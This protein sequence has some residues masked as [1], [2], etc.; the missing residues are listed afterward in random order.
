MSERSDSRSRTVNW[1]RAA[2]C[3]LALL[4]LAALLAPAFAAGSAGPIAPQ[5]PELVPFEQVGHWVSPAINLQQLLAEDRANRSRK[6]IPYRIG[7]PMTVDFTPANSGTWEDLRGGGRVWRFVVS[8]DAAIWVVLGFDVYDLPEGASLFVYDPAQKTV[9]GPYTVSDVREHHQLWTPP[10]EGDTLVV[11][12]NWPDKLKGSEPKL[13]LGTVSHGY[14]PF[15]TIGRAAW[16]AGAGATEAE[17][18][19][20]SCN[21]DTMCP[22]GANWQNEKRGVVILLS[23]GSGFCSASLINTTA[24]DCRPYVLTAHHCLAGASTVFGFNFEHTACGSGSPGLPTLHTVSGATVLADYAWSSTA[25]Q[26]SDFTLLQMSSQ[27][28]EAFNVYYNGWN[29]GTAA[30]TETHVIHHPSGDVKKISYDADPA[31]DGTLG[32]GSTGYGPSHWRIAHY[33]SGTTEG[34]SSG[35]PL[36]DQNHHI[37]GQ[38]HGGLASCTVIDWDEYGKVAVSWDGGGTSASRLSDWLDPNVTGDLTMDGVDYQ[39][40]AFNPAGVVTLARDILACTDTITITVRDDNLRGNPT[41]D[42]TITSNTETTPETVTLTAREPGSGFFDGTFPVA[43]IPAVHGDGTLSVSPGDTVTVLYIDADNGSGGVNVPVTATA[44]VDCVGPVITNVRS[45]NVTGNSAQV[46]WDTNETSN[47]RVTYD[48]VIPP[49]AG[50]ATSA[51]LGVSHQVN[52]TGLNPCS[53]YYYSVTST[54]AAG[55][56]TTDT[57]GGLYYTFKTGTNVSPTYTSTDTPIAIPDNNTTGATSTIHVP[58]FDYLSKL[59]VTVNV[60]H[61]YDGDLSLSLIAPDGTTVIPLSTRRGTSGDNFT[62]TVFDDAATTAISAGTAPFTGPFKPESPLSVLNGTASYG[63]WKLLVVD[64]A[65]SDTG[66]IL[67]W[68]LNMSFPPAPCGASVS[69]DQ[70]IYSCSSAMAITVRDTNVAGATLTV[71]AASATEP[72]GETVTLTRQPAPKDTWF[73]GSITLTSPPPVGGDGLLSVVNADSITVTYIDADDGQGNTNVPVTGT[74]TTLCAPPVIT[75]V[76]SS[77]VQGSSAVINWTTNVAASSV[78]HYGT[79][80]PP[81]STS[82][83]ASRVT[84]HA[85]PLAGLSSCSTYYYSV[86]STDAYGNTAIDNN[87][88]NYYVFVTPQN[89]NA[90]YTSTDTPLAIPD[91]NATGITSTINVPDLDQVT[92]VNVLVNLTHTFDGDLNLSLVAPNG[93][94]VSL[95]ARRGSTG[96]NFTNTVF[97]DAATTPIAS[98]TAPFTGSFKPESPLSAVNGIPA[99]GAWKLKVVDAAGGDTGTLLNWTLQVAYQ[100]RVCGP[101]ASYYSK[102][103]TDSCPSGGPGS[104]NGVV[105]RGEDITMPVTIRNDGAV[106]LTGVSGTLTTT[107]PDVTITLATAAFPDVPISL[108]SASSAPHFG[109]TVGPTVPCGADI[110]F[111]LAIHTAQGTFHSSFTVKVGLAG[112]AT[113]TYTSTDVPKPVPDNSTTGNTSAITVSDTHLVTKVTVRMSMTHTFDGDLNLSLIAPNGT[114]VPLS[115]RRGSSGDNFTNTVFDD[116]A[117]TPIASGTSPFT[118][119]F[120][121]E[122][123]L[124][125]VNG[126]PANGAWTLKVV[127]TASGD[128]G[129]ITAFSLDIT[130]AV[131]WICIDCIPALPTGEPIQQ[132]WVGKTGQQ[133]EPIAGATSYHMYRGVAADLPKLLTADPESCARLTTS[134]PTTGPVLTESPAAGGLYWYLVRAAN[135]AGEGPA[136]SANPGGP[137]NQ[138]SSGACP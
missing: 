74:A 121:P 17:G 83:S 37:V 59:T 122:S 65:A 85:L 123:P 10:I 96:D 135:I 79:T 16:M 82:S 111:S 40:C 107:T 56:S 109:F 77:N 45:Q 116:A 100:P 35:S 57:N 86:E 90:S 117:T 72:L 138:S 88:G 124:N 11:E 78:V 76:F 105:E 36:F 19:S 119:S 64:G 20:G 12:L 47:S 9:Q 53:T 94:T 128:T 54:D 125:V 68:S 44:A 60:A 27:A 136:G 51:A 67:N 58:Y 66:T 131:G 31:V 130:T 92:D 49:V 23:G 48:T 133:W 71:K 120:T 29:H 43:Q 61:T 113:T 84:A 126:I 112:T 22:L 137:R 15:G 55:N 91:N 102:T 2:G 14:K 13:H 5:R 75:N 103:V 129:T 95:A 127:D 97:D 39:T 62:A 69:L 32:G 34:G 132:V 18:D 81:A 98:G 46:L 106:V 73:Q 6:D 80:I 33:T 52:V 118:G 70:G 42:V 38:L 110:A 99:V 3:A 28:P 25:P 115:S 108:T 114:I 21:I 101:S 104:G 4:A 1:L 7:F 50:T 8:S 41:Q 87:G 26:G 30:P 93:T 24:N 89:T 134:A 63:D